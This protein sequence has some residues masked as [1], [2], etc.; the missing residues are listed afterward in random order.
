MIVEGQVKCQIFFP[1]FV[2]MLVPSTRSAQ[3]AVGDNG[4]KFAG[5]IDTGII[6]RDFREDIYWVAKILY[7]RHVGLPEEVSCENHDVASLSPSMYVIQFLHAPI[8]MGPL[9]LSLPMRSL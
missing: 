2:L 4:Q 5:I 9:T 7:P 1:R 8:V 6:S 3:S